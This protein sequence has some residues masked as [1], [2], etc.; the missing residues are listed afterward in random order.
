M[1]DLR[2]T[3]VT[4]D[5]ETERNRLLNALAEVIQPN[6]LTAWLQR[7]N[8]HF[9]GST[10]IQ[11]IERGEADRLWRMIWQLREGNSASRA[12]CSCDAASPARL[13]PHR[14]ASLLWFL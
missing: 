11:V 10:P 9:D 14:L 3:N 5:R 8:K 2:P 6:Q 1:A 4:A 13:C 7:P 12:H